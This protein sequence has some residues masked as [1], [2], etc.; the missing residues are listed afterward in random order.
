MTEAGPYAR[1]LAGKVVVVLGGS[2]GIGLQTA[3][4]AR[5]GATVI[6]TG[7]DAERLEK[8]AELVTPARTEPSTSPTI[9]R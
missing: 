9:P 7:R 2:S 1:T 5:A 8:A 3:L 6:L 4:Q